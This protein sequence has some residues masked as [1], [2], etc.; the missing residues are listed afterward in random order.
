MK[1]NTSAAEGEGVY[2]PRIMQ[3]GVSDGGRNQ[4]ERECRDYAVN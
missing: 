2:L 1:K 4:R 3:T